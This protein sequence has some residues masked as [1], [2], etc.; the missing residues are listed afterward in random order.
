[1]QLQFQTAEVTSPHSHL[2]DITHI[3]HHRKLLRNPQPNLKRVIPSIAQSLLLAMQRPGSHPNGSELEHKSLHCAITDSLVKEGAGRPEL[4][5]PPTCIQRDVKGSLRLRKD[6][7]AEDCRLIALRQSSKETCRNRAVASKD[8]LLDSAHRT[9]R[10]RPLCCTKSCSPVYSKFSEVQF[11]AVM[12][13]SQTEAVFDT[14]P[15]SS[16]RLDSDDVSS[17]IHL[18][19]I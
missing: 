19:G 8:L 12:V 15:K 1:M 9:L 5:P 16:P 18:Q 6:P 10:P 3:P 4:A 7:P 17:S 13:L 2:T 11:G 14:E